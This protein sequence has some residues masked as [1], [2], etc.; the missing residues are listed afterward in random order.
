LRGKK[1]LRGKKTI[2][3][4]IAI[5]TTPEKR[6]GIQGGGERKGGLGSREGA[7]GSGRREGIGDVFILFAGG[8]K[9]Q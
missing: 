4:S 6:R 7:I 5:T 9:L 1:A 2:T 8:E 3:H